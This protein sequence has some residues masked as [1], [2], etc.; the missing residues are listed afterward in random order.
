MSASRKSTAP[1]RWAQPAAIAVVIVVHGLMLGVLLRSPQP[2]GVAEDAR[3]AVY[4]L[5]RPLPAPV[6][7]PLATPAPPMPQPAASQR[8]PAPRVATPT[9]ASHAAAVDPQAP[10]AAL[11]LSVPG[12]LM[13][14]GIDAALLVPRVLGN[15]EVHPAFQPKPK[16]FRMKAGMTPEQIV[17]GIFQLIGAWPPGYT[18]DPCRLTR[19]QIDYLRNAVDEMDRDLLRE[20]LIRHSQDC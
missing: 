11:D 10:R 18:V 15:R 4:W 1:S 3:L 17:H 20:S 13:G 6:P 2:G 8:L 16:R 12:S 9:I 14:N 7:P 19:Q 5:P